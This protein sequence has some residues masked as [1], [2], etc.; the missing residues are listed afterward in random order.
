MR[1]F[2]IPDMNPSVGLHLL[3]LAYFFLKFTYKCFFLSILDGGRLLEVFPLFPLAD[4]AFLLHHALE[5]LDSLL[6]VLSLVNAYLSYEN[7]HLSLE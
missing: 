7:H 1:A 5:A 6:E 4:N 2:E 3:K